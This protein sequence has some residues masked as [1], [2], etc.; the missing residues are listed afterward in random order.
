M[1]RYSVL[2]TGAAGGIGGAT[3]RLLAERGHRV[4]A[5]VRPGR[6]APMT[7]AAI[8]ATS[9]ITAAYPPRSAPR[10]GSWGHGR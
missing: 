8:A 2:T 1:P 6:P 7:A 4:F 9:R 10:S 5:D 3:V